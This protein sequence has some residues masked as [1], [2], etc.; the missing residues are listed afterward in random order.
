MIFHPFIVFQSTSIADKGQDDNLI[1]G[2]K[3]YYSD[4]VRAKIRYLLDLPPLENCP[5]SED[6]PT[7][8]VI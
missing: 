7:P 5:Q 1:T 3:Q 6:A 4:L 8:F 2:S